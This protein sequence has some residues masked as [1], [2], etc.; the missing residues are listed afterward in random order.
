MGQVLSCRRRAV[1]GWWPGTCA[2]PQH[3]ILGPA[4]FGAL[5][6]NPGTGDEH[7]VGTFVDNTTFGGAVESLD[8]RGASQ[9]D[10]SS[11]SVHPQRAA[12]TMHG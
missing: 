10:T 12:C 3:S 1:S 9:K 2:A 6:S 7:T 11:V 8:D 4:L 5:L